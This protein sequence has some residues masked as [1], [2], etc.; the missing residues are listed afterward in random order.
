[1]TESN[2]YLF[3]QSSL[4]LVIYSLKMK[5]ILIGI[6]ITS[7]SGEQLDIVLEN[8]PSFPRLPFIDV[9][10]VQLLHPSGSEYARMLF[11]TDEFYMVHPR[12]EGEED[13]V[14]V[15][16]NSEGRPVMNF[17]DGPFVVRD[18]Y[19]G[20]R[21]SRGGQRMYYGAKK[22]AGF[23]SEVGSFLLTPAGTN[24]MRLIIRPED[25][26]N[27]CSHESGPMV[28]VPIRHQTSDWVLL[29]RVRPLAVEQLALLTEYSIGI[30]D[31]NATEP[32]LPYHLSSG[33]VCDNIPFQTYQVIR[34]LIS[35]TGALVE[36]SGTARSGIT[37]RNCTG[38]IDAFPSIQYSLYEGTERG[39]TKIVDIVL[40]A[41][42]YTTIEAG[43]VCIAHIAPSHGTERSALGMNLLRSTAM[44][45]DE[46]NN[47]VGLCDFREL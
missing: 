44:H 9:R 39:T 15:G 33:D 2:L 17:L 5:I 30:S 14:A 27:F 25:P 10:F 12:L 31:S 47:R 13:S 11:H 7:A 4:L 24:N 26:Q 19:V 16:F 45:F 29:G 36:E 32:I 6:I 35:A 34:G 42:E 18:N 21:S 40:T 37:I 23:A 28:Y 20:F 1:M 43:D 38:N 46:T 8:D 3:L 22:S 41:R